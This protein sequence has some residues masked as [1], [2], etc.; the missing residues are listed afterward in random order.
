MPL[1]KQ[2]Q[3]QLIFTRRLLSLYTLILEYNPHP[4]LVLNEFITGNMI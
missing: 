4:N 2:K 3:K 1:K